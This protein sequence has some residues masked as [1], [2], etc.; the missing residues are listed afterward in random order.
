MWAGDVEVL[1]LG[2]YHRRSHGRK[3]ERADLI[4]SAPEVAG[5]AGNDPATNGLT[6]RRRNLPS[7]KVALGW[8]EDPRASRRRLRKTP[9]LKSRL[10]A[11]R[12]QIRF[13]IFKQAGRRRKTLMKYP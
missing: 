2:Q 7:K 10:R 12:S 1:D 6:V 4:I 5:R 13:E 3:K 11:K 8:G 9:Y